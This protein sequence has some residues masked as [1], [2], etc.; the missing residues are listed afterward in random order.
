MG[1]KPPL[2]RSMTSIQITRETKTRLAGFGK[3]GDTYEDIIIRLMDQME[4]KKK[5]LK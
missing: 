2:C 4:R 1:N 3:K 5:A